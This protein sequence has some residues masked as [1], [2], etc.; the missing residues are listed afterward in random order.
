MTVVKSENW[1][2][3]AIEICILAHFGTQWCPFNYLHLF[4]HVEYV[5]ALTA[6]WFFFFFFALSES[7]AFSLFIVCAF[8]FS[9]PNN[10]TLTFSLCSSFSITPLSFLCTYSPSSCI[11]LFLPLFC[12]VGR[13]NFRCLVVVVELTFCMMDAILTPSPALLFCVSSLRTA[14]F[15]LL[16]LLWA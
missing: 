2:C 5:L 1:F 8:N 13:C 7:F 3:T 6:I 15:L 10:I 16:L 12:V 11:S 4:D 14:P 9:L